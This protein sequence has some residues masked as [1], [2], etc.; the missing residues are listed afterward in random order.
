MVMISSTVPAAVALRAG[1]NQIEIET[2][3]YLSDSDV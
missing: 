2:S 1:Q 3:I